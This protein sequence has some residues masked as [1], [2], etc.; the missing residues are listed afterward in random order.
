M[1]RIPRTATT[2]AVL[3]VAAV[4][5]MERLDEK[6]RANPVRRVVTMLQMMQKKIVA[7]GEK[8]KELYEKF[9]CYC[10]N[11][12]A[13]LTKAVADSTASVPD[14]Q[15]QIEELEAKIAQ[16]KA[17]VD[18]HQKDRAAAKA[19]IEEATEIRKKEHKSFLKCKEGMESQMA[20]IKK[21][22]GA[23]QALEKGAYGMTQTEFIQQRA[24]AA[25][26]SG[27]KSLLLSDSLS[28]PDH[29]R[30][31]LASFLSEGA[32]EDN[33]YTPQ[34]GEIIG[35][36]KQML[37][38]AEASK[39]TCTNE[40]SSKVKTFKALL[41]AK[42]KEIDA[43]T[44]LIEAKIKLIGE[45]EVKLVNL[46]EQLTDEE[47]TLVENKKLLGNIDK[48]CD[49]KKKE[50][51]LRVKT[52]GE[53]LLAIADTIKIL[54]DDD[55]LDLFK[56]TL[57]SASLMQVPVRKGELR[58]RA[59]ILLQRARNEVDRPRR[60]NLSLLILAL[61]GKKVS[62]TKVIKMIDD[63]VALLKEEQ[64]ADDNKKEYCEVTI[65]HTEDS[66]KELE[67]DISDLSKAI[68]DMTS[69]IATLGEEIVALKE[70]IVSLDKSVAE[71]TEQRKEENEDYT[72]LMASNTAALE[73]LEMAKNRLNKF[74]NPKLYK[75]PPT[76]PA[77]NAEWAHLELGQQKAKPVVMEPP[78]E[79]WGAYEKKGEES[80]S[81]IGMIDD[82]KK[83]LEVE[84][85]EA[86]AEEKNS[87][88]EYETLMA[89]SAEKRVT[90][91]NAIAAKT[92]EKAELEGD[93]VQAKDDKGNKLKEAM[94]TEKFLGDLHLEC[95]WLLKNFVLRKEARDSEIDA[96]GKAKA[97][98]SGADYSFIQK[99][100]VTLRTTARKLQ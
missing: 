73:L 91:T 52:R 15:S 19:A 55:A 70:G 58:K 98:L 65:D 59:L 45:L 86:T 71:A 6:Q 10:K 18:M 22:M 85:S 7:E 79:T 25:A 27:V 57:P 46:K 95:D 100:G 14:L 39:D 64:L 8:E 68:D 83:E 2:I 99:R 56:K 13:D 81:V 11:G 54:N 76:T 89:E 47:A 3:V 66:K 94:A 51:E 17:D 24:G 34:S 32:G 16:L 88:E 1:A 37:D 97:V 78:P 42:L 93:L 9:M 67:H 96:L 36:L 50:Y 77:P 41:A 48:I 72:A 69:T 90:D 40:E 28:L 82:L 31:T 53:E 29:D 20:L 92:G 62:M 44:K 23:I 38:T 63:M 84:M 61:S 75:P 12:K 60:S 74:Y 21:M 80:N 35:I 5:G 4:Q 30:E 87:Q 33:G 43:L 49:A 26:V